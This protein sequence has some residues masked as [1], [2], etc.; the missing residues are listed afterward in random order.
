MSFRNNLKQNRKKQTN[1]G[2][3]KKAMT[4]INSNVDHCKYFTNIRIQLP[5]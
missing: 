2:T 4:L 5:M 3:G 1:N